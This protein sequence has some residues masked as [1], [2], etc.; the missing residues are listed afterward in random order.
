M[1]AEQIVKFN[2]VYDVR[3]IDSSI[4]QS[5]RLLYFMN[6]VRLSVT[7]LQQVM[8]GPTIANVMWTAVQLTRVWTTAYRWVKM[9]NDAQRLGIAQSA[10]GGMG[11]GIGAAAARRFALGQ[12]TLALGAGGAM[13]ITPAQTGLFASLGALAMANPLLAGLA[14]FAFVVSGLGYRQ[15]FLDRQM[16]IENEEQRK[17]MREIAK[18]QGYDF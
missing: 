3:G 11:R 14:A 17:R 5:Q 9:T 1:S 10:A 16:K 15:F 7:D 12:T 2:V 6:A 8:S 18:S 4:R 13:G